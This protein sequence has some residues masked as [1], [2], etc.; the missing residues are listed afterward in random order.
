MLCLG[1]H[2]RN[3]YNKQNRD[4]LDLFCLASYTA[5]DQCSPRAR[6][7]LS[8]CHFCGSELTIYSYNCFFDLLL[9]YIASAA[10]LLPH[11]VFEI[12]DVSAG[13]IKQ[14]CPMAM[15]ILR[16]DPYCPQRLHSVC[17]LYDRD[18]QKRC[19]CLEP[20]TSIQQ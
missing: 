7:R 19:E 1:R 12:N 2:N 6:W 11:L 16:S 15:P 13:A 5:Q 3:N 20:L 4:S 9:P 14:G 8:K 17:A 18:L 10:V